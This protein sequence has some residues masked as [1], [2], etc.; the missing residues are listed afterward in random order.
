M[1]PTFTEG[2][3]SEAK[4]TF[5]RSA[6]GRD[7]NERFTIRSP[8]S[9]RSG[10]SAIT[11]R[12]WFRIWFAWWVLTILVG[13]ESEMGSGRACHRE[14]C[15]SSRWDFEDYIGSTEGFEE[16]GSDRGRAQQKTLRKRSN[17]ETYCQLYLDL[18]GRKGRR[19]RCLRRYDRWR[20]DVCP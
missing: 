8:R 9:A 1:L 11:R 17:G 14:W 13:V 20:R 10:W 6:S 5:W 12:C 2:T 3:K 15:S 18:D 4:Y 19:C 7:E 16:A